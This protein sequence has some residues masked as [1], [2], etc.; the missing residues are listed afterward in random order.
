M[1]ERL[2]NLGAVRRHLSAAG[3]APRFTGR[4]L[5]FRVPV[6][7]KPVACELLWEPERGVLRFL[8]GMP[9]SWPSECPDG[10]DGAV[11]SLNNELSD[12]AFQVWSQGRRFV[13]FGSHIFLSHDGTVSAFAVDELL[14][15]ARATVEW[16]VERIEPLVR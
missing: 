16:G 3:L 14:R 9:I 7:G 1:S 15:K 2:P 11:T 13:L 10:V 8:L 5:F 4:G 6:R 12:G